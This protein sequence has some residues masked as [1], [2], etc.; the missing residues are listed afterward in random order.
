MGE[1]YA[2]DVERDASRIAG[3]FAVE[4]NIRRYHLINDAELTNECMTVYLLA[5][6]EF[7]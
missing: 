7:K 6:F 5:A 1:F 4:H 2:R 3:K